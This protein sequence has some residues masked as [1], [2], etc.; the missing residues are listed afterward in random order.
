LESPGD[1][2]HAPRDAGP[3]GDRLLARCRVAG[4]RR[5]AASPSR[6]LL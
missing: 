1:D 5:C 4:A 2:V 3:K 6:P